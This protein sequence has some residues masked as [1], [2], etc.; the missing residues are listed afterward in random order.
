MQI[1]SRNISSGA[2]RLFSSCRY[3]DFDKPFLSPLS[4]SVFTGTVMFTLLNNNLKIMFQTLYQENQEIKAEIN[5]LR[6]EIQKKWI[7]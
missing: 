5:R 3:N 4:A 7:R 1:V 6:E 2:K